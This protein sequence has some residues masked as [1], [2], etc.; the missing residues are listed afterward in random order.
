MT[1]AL[2]ASFNEL[3]EVHGERIGAPL[4]EVTDVLRS[5]EARFLSARAETP[6]ALVWKLR[7]LAR[8][9]ENDWHPSEMASLADSIMRDV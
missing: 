8:A 3:E 1:A 5:L 7:R 6:D 9:L 2:I 4:D